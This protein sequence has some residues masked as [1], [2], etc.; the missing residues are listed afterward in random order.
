M[1]EDRA[2]VKATLSRWA[3][4]RRRQDHGLTGRQSLH[5][6]FKTGE[7]MINIIMAKHEQFYLEP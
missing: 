5:C 3:L 1:A 7:G 6:H 2:W 4:G